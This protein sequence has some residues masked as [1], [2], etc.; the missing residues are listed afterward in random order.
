MRPAV[1]KIALSVFL[2]SACGKQREEPP[3]VQ[4]QS[5]YSGE[6]TQLL[7]VY[8]WSAEMGVISLRDI[9]AAL[10]EA[11]VLVLNQ[12]KAGSASFRAFAAELLRGGLGRNSR[13]KPRV[14]FVQNENAY[15]PWPR[16]QALVDERGIMWMSASNSHQLRDIMLALDASYGVQGRAA[17]FKFAGA[18]LLQSG[19]TLLCPD[20]LD[21]TYLAQHL[22]GPFLTLPSPA[23]PAPFHLDLLVMPLSERVVVVGDDQ[24]A[25][26]YL[27]AL[28]DD[29]IAQIV[30]QWLQDFAAAANNFDFHMKDG[31]ASWRETERPALILQALLQEKMKKIAPLAQ[32]GNFREAVRAEPN[33]DWDDQIAERLARSGFKVVR[34]PFWPATT[35]VLPML[36]YPNSLV[37]DEGILMPV[38]NIAGLDSLA[39][40]R[41]EKAS[42]K[43][44]Y[45]VRGGAMLGYGNS[46]PHCLT[47]E[48]RK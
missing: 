8:T 15:G 37:W 42:R 34:V 13:G 17:A 36:C 23:P 20:R 2:F 21:T 5:A 39:I 46:G 45:P 9:L 47:L 25:R 30:S 29:Q 43:K 11:D 48:F 35:G 6:I 38:Y 33:Y 12:F 19:K 7:L 16:D 4:M 28:Q 44:I 40:S 26:N 18:N 14:Q 31:R 3:R 32:S 41:W 22:R 27:L 10:P 1:L 24:L